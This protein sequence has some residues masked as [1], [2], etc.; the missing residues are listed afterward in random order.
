M[1][2]LDFVA[3]KMPVQ[4]PKLTAAES[5]EDLVAEATAFALLLWLLCLLLCLGTVLCLSAAGLSRQVL[6]A[7]ALLAGE[8][9]RASR[10]LRRGAGDAVDFRR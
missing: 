3:A 7:H 4:S 5:L 10:E 9:G 1:V 8:V 2:I 6:V